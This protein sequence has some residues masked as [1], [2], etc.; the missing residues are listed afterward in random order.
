MKNKEK[1]SYITFSARVAGADSGAKSYAATVDRIEAVLRR[2]AEEIPGLQMTG[3]IGIPVWDGKMSLIPCWFADEEVTR[4]MLPALLVDYA[5]KRT[6]EV[7]A[8]AARE[9]MHRVVLGLLAFGPDTNDPQVA[10][11]IIEGLV[12]GMIKVIQPER[13]TML[14]EMSEDVGMTPGQMLLTLMTEVR[15]D[16]LEKFLYFRKRDTH[17]EQ[18]EE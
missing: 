8:D 7:G 11:S 6:K 4:D 9:E 10:L 16:F 17:K 3:E 2:L 14:C 5:A 13:W 18:D 15:D 1:S 12:E